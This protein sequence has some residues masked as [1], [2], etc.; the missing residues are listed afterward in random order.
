MTTESHIDH[1]NIVYQ[2][3][4]P[5]PLR[6]LFDYRPRCIKQRIEPGS[7]VVVPFGPRTV[8]GF[9]MSKTFKSTVPL[10]KLKLIIEILDEEPILPQEILSI[11]KWS[12]DYY[13]HPIGQVLSTAVPK[14][15]AAIVKLNLKSKPGKALKTYQSQKEI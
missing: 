4:V 3:A 2:V 7:R 6:R 12:S 10:S 13:H 9:V 5:S 1:E 8:V 11:L 14:K 15:Y